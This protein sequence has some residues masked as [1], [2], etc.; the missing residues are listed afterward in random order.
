MNYPKTFRQDA[1]AAL[2]NTG[3][4]QQLFERAIGKSEVEI[5]R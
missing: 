5:W 3:K 1:C 2:R 4:N